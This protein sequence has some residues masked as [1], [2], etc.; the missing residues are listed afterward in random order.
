MHATRAPPPPRGSRNPAPVRTV[1]TRPGG[2][3]AAPVGRAQLRLTGRRTPP[4]A[5]NPPLRRSYARDARSPAAARRPQRRL[6]RRAL[7]G[8]RAALAHRA[9]AAPSLAGL[10]ERPGHAGRVFTVVPHPRGH[11]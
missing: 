3:R 4:A 5:P 2:N 1:H 11:V 10:L 9:S 7:R 8:A 6:A